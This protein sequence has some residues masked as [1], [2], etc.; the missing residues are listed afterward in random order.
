MAQNAVGHAAEN[1]SREPASSVA[2]HHDEIASVLVGTFDD[3][4]H[5]FALDLFGRRT[6][7][8]RRS[9]V[10]RRSERRLPFVGYALNRGLGV[11]ERSTLR[12]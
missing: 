11:D 8:E 3:A 7:A 6:H 9:C 12:I 2:S 4:M 5:R 10:G 1:Q